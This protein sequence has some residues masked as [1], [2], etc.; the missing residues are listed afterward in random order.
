[1]TSKKIDNKNKIINLI[2]KLDKAKGLELESIKYKLEQYGRS[3]T[4]PFFNNWEKFNINQKF[5]IID[6][7]CKFSSTI[8]TKHATKK[9]LA[10]ENQKLKASL[11]TLIGNSG[12]SKD[13]PILAHSLNSKDKR[14]RANTVEAI[15]RLGGKEI[16]ELLL[17]LL[18]D[19]NNRVKANT[20][21][22]LWEFEEVRKLVKE[23][24]EEMVKDDSKWMKASGYYAFGEIGI[25]DFFTLLLESLDEEDEDIARNAVVA[26][27]G[28]ADKYGEIL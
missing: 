9:Y 23:V 10:E 18:K 3:I 26:L 13:I 25:M 15:S 8:I 21:K 4:L 22:A 19:P 1:M 24:F 11:I 17:P 6:I 12:N 2:E 27:V 7:L 28:Y 5:Q 14:I 16:I 20:A